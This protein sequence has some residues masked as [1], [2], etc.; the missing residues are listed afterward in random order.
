MS[1]ETTQETQEAPSFSD[2]L[3][4]TKIPDD[5]E[6]PLKSYAGKSLEEALS[7]GYKGLQTQ[8]NESQTENKA[9]KAQVE[10]LKKAQEKTEPPPKQKTETK[11]EESPPEQKVDHKKLFGEAIAKATNEYI[12][13][14]G[15]GIS[16]ETIEEVQKATGATERDI[17]RLA[18]SAWQERQAINE[19]FQEQL[20]EFDMGKLEGWILSKES[21]YTKAEAQGMLA[22]A[23]KGNFG[24]IPA[25][26]NEM[27]AFI[28]EGGTF[29]DP[30]SGQKEGNVQQALRGN[31]GGGAPTR[32]F[33]T[34]AEMEEARS[35]A[36]A[37]GDFSA[38]QKKY[39][40]T[41]E[42]VRQ[43]WNR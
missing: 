1:D 26:W 3:T 23:K 33:K 8:F 6:G 16:A 7:K 2:V 34:K 27:Q 32:G 10:E 11:S 31:P 40:E 43:S 28:G 39:N 4:N 25:A 42:K 15:K 13:N 12:T 14:E 29:T 19:Q 30:I 38:F 41:P 17:L 20:E 22:L 37:K 35:A 9:L 24:W 36:K 18:D 5:A 21:N